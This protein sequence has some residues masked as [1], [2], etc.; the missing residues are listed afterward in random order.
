LQGYLRHK[1]TGFHLLYIVTWVEIRAECQSFSVL[2]KNTTLCTL[3]GLEPGLLDPETSPLTMRP[4][5]VYKSLYNSS[6][7]TKT[8]VSYSVHCTC[9]IG[10]VY[11]QDPSFASNVA[12]QPKHLAHLLDQCQEATD[13]LQLFHPK[14]EIYIYMYM[15]SNILKFLL[16]YFKYIYIYY[17]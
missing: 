11:L 12:L 14:Q 6:A 1:F 16:K 2:S 4:A 5:T 3:P 9:I 17:M 13:C 15:T 8:H 10:V 7:D